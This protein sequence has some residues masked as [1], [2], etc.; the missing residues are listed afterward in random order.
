MKKYS[1]YFAIFYLILV[2]QIFVPEK[3]FAQFI[4]F[5][6]W[7]IPYLR[8]LYVFGNAAVNPF[9]FPP[10][11]DAFLQLY[12]GNQNSYFMTS[13]YSS[14]VL[15][16]IKNE[17]RTYR[18][19]DSSPFILFLP[20]VEDYSGDRIFTNEK[21]NTISIK[22]QGYLKFSNNLS[23]F[24]RVRMTTLIN[25]V[26]SFSGRFVRER[27]HFQSAEADYAFFQY[28][29]NFANIR[30]GRIKEGWGSFGN[31]SLLLST[32]GASYDGFRVHLRLKN[33]EYRVFSGYLETVLDAEKQVDVHRYL[34][35]HLFTYR[36]KNLSL[37]VG[38]TVVYSG[39][40]RPLDFSYLIPFIPFL[41]SDA[42][43][44]F[45]ARVQEQ[46][47]VFFLM[48]IDYHQP[49]SFH[50]SGTLLLD[51]FQIDAKDRRR[52]P[53]NYGFNIL[54]EIP[55]SFFG[56][57]QMSGLQF[58]RVG[59]WVYRYHR[60]FTNYQSRGLLLGS[61]YGSD[62]TGLH[63]WQVFYPYPSFR[64]QLNF[65][66]FRSGERNISKE[67]YGLK[68]TF[69]KLSPPSGVVENTLQLYLNLRYQPSTLFYSE[70]IVGYQKQKNFQNNS[71]I[72]NN[73]F[74]FGLHIEF[75]FP[76]SLY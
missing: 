29:N 32:L 21:R 36:F 50:L 13:R 2:G 42:N 48:G 41:E 45:N 20:V 70:V 44:R 3:S 47:N 62:Y 39:E 7:S 35:G 64:A 24:S 71:G 25:G 4:P 52:I 74:L 18:P 22:L 63:F 40:N 54:S 1:Q 14:S 9:V 46:D 56:I 30:L 58:S 6:H 57:P 16:L 19:T 34:A 76:V 75:Y 59:S 23:A 26:Q 33:F 8:D 12:E 69:S 43:L 53:D 38:E 66:L 31:N 55:Y 73:Q 5:D 67:L 28:H 15:R 37:M 17:Y 60:P 11:A 27:F 61:F 65:V 49:H 10:D 72:D 68:D 51:D